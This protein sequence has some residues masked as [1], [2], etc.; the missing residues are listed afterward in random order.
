MM[1]FAVFWVV[2]CSV[3]W[4]DTSISED[5]AASVFR[6][7]HWYPTTTLHSATTQKTTN[8]IFTAV[9]TSNLM[10]FMML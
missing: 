4:L 2:P 5:C 1:E 7:Q 8:S 9:K 10:K 3:W 6:V